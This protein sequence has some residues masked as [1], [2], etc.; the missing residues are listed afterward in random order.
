MESARHREPAPRATTASWPCGFK[1]AW[2][3]NRHRPGGPGFTCCQA[4]DLR[5]AASSLTQ[6]ID[7]V[8]SRGRIHALAADRVGENPADRTPSGLWPSDHA[9]ITSVL[10]LR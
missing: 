5:N 8:L 7:Y 4:P 2:T 6:R 3:A 1:D 10:R 9:D